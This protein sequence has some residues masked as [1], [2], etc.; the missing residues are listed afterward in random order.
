MIKL[1][2]LRGKTRC[3]N[4]LGDYGNEQMIQLKWSGKRSWGITQPFCTD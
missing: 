3:I 1:I 4:S 2:N